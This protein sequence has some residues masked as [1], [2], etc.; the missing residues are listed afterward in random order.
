VIAIGQLLLIVLLLLLVIIVIVWLV[1]YWLAIDDSDIV[2]QPIAQ[3]NDI[4]QAD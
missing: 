4:S 2:T 1:C 3:P